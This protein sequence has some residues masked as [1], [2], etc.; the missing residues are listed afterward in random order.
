M[1]SKVSDSQMYPGQVQGPSMDQQAFLA[2]HTQSPGSCACKGAKVWHR[3]TRPLAQP[4]RGLCLDALPTG[5]CTFRP[6]FLGQIWGYPKYPRFFWGYPRIT[7]EFWGKF[8]VTPKKNL[9]QKNKVF[10]G[11]KNITPNFW[12]I[13]QKFGVTPEL[14]QISGVYPKFLGWFFFSRSPV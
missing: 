6:K 1:I 12:G 7:P 5:L 10:W 2:W 3:P 13:P 9:P 11:K 8:G 14:P 4:A